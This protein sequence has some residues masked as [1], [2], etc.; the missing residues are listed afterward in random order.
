MPSLPY[1][2]PFTDAEF[3]QLA[4]LH[5]MNGDLPTAWQM[6]AIE[7]LRAR[8]EGSGDIVRGKDDG[9]RLLPMFDVGPANNGRD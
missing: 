4:D 3:L 8:L 5:L 1:P 9:P 6:S 7:R 2:R